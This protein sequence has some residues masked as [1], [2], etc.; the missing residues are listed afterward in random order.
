MKMKKSTFF[1]MKL[2]LKSRKND[3]KKNKQ[4]LNKNPHICAHSYTLLKKKLQQMD[5]ILS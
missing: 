3:C 4:N 1:K 5:E 2:K